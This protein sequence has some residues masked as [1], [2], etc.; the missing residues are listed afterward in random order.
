MENSIHRKDLEYC[1]KVYDLLAQLEENAR[2]RNE[3]VREAKRVLDKHVHFLASMNAFALPLILIGLFILSEDANFK[4]I[5]QIVNPDNTGPFIASLF[6]LIFISALIWMNVYFTFI[7]LYCKG[8]FRWS[9]QRVKAKVYATMAAK[10]QEI[11]YEQALIIKSDYLLISRIPD[12]FLSVLG[13]GYLI[14]NL[15]KHP[16]STLENELAELK[17]DIQNEDFR[18]TIVPEGKTMIQQE[19][20][21]HYLDFLAEIFD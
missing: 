8:I 2:K 16:E 9:K 13:L 20:E 3:L 12:E 11:G 19:R 6:G 5:S 17:R 21:N 15:E 4:G 14:R 10:K 18:R 1:Y 7:A